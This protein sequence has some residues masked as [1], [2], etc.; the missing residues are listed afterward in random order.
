MPSLLWLTVKKNNN[1]MFP[2]YSWSL[3]S[4]R[5]S[6]LSSPLLYP[7]SPCFSHLSSSLLSPFSFFLSPLCSF[8]Y[9]L[10]SPCF[11]NRSS[12]L[13][14]SLLSPLRSSLL[15]P[16]P[17][18]SSRWSCWG[19]REALW[20]C[21]FPALVSL[22]PRI[23]APSNHCMYRKDFI[24]NEHFIFYFPLRSHSMVWI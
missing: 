6:S 21:S 20:L 5:L 23:W 18:P 19:Y 13:S 10:P 7:L 16:Y 8:L 22:L 4:P 2:G 3:L 15:S 1:H 24:K 11:S 9:P 12:P 17:L 14:S